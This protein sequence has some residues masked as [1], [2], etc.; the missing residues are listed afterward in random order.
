[1]AVQGVVPTAETAVVNR[2]L[3]LVELDGELAD[4]RTDQLSGVCETRV[5]QCHLCGA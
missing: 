3:A 4:K 5:Y 1:M 2:A